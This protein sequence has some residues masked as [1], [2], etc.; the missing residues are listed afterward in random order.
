MRVIIT[1]HW[2]PNSNGTEYTEALGIYRDLREAAQDGQEYASDRYEWPSEAEQEEDGIEC[3]GPDVV[4]E[5]YDPAEHDGQRAGG[6][7]FEDDFLDF[8]RKDT[9]P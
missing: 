4:L 9:F 2:H 6:G 1:S 8:D 3:E 7:S 5:E